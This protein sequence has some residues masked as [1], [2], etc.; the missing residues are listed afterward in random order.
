[1]M[2]METLYAA[3]PILILIILMGVMKVS[4]DKSSV[5]TL[6]ITAFLALFA[7]NLSVPDTINSFL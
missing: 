2:Y 5:I 6:F 1:M 7:F 4:G 3:L